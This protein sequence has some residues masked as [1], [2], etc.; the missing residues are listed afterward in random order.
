MIW[1]SVVE[2]ERCMCTECSGPVALGGSSIAA[3]DSHLPNRMHK[4]H[5]SCFSD[6]PLRFGMSAKSGTKLNDLPRIRFGTR[7]SIAHD[8]KPPHGGRDS[9]PSNRSSNAT[10][11]RATRAQSPTGA[12]QAHRRRRGRSVGRWT[13]R[14]RAPRP[15]PASSTPRR[16]AK[17]LDCLPGD[18]PSGLLVR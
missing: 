1:D 8:A 15:E 16:G 10:H 13:A 5:A 2:L 6:R 14:G 17:A 7:I 18:G 9:L 4:A 3:V 12:A 11:G